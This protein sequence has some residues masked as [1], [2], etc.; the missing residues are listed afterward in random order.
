MAIRRL[1]KSRQYDFTL[2]GHGRQRKA[3]Y[4]TKVEA[5][6]AQQRRREDLISGRKRYLL[7]DACAM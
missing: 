4:R 3:G 7:A 6:E 1:D 5:R 2:Q